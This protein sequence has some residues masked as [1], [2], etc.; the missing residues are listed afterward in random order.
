MA[1]P[2][3]PKS[4]WPGALKSIRE[5]DPATQFDIPAKIRK[6]CEFDDSPDGGSRASWLGAKIRLVSF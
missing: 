3:S 6:V 1:I 2:L 4:Y 5:E